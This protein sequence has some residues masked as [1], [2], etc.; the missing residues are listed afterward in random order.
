MGETSPP[1]IGFESHPGA[2]NIVLDEPSVGYM[3]FLRQNAKSWLYGK[4]STKHTK[5]EFQIHKE[6]LVF[7]AMKSMTYCA[8]RI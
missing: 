1:A 2:F 5:N 6:Y 7:K 8:K 4:A 3:G